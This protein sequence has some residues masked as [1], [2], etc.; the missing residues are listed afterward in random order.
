[1]P[2]WK[3]NIAPRLKKGEDVLIVAH[4]NSLRALVMELDAMGR[5]EIV[6]LNIPTGVPLAYELNDDL[7]A[8]DRRFLGDP[9]AVRAAQEA[10]ATQLQQ[11]RQ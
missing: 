11:A 5:E 7:R 4:G 9:D 10:V 1:M 6:G 3:T 8:V 2:H